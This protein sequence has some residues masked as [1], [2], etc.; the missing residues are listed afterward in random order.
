ML[1]GFDLGQVL[2]TYLRYQSAS[3]LVDILKDMP[4]TSKGFF[5]FIAS[6]KKPILSRNVKA[7]MSQLENL[8]LVMQ[9]SIKSKQAFESARI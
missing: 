5:A 7:A 3:S 9:A 6:E 8:N 2:T 4:V 1:R